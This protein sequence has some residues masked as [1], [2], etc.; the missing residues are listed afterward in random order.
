MNFTIEDL[1]NQ[2]TDVQ[3]RQVNKRITEI[4]EKRKEQKL[5][6]LPSLNNE[7]IHF[8]ESGQ[9]IKAMATY[10]QRTQVGL[11]NSKWKV[12]DYLR[13]RV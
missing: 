10:A 11:I 3:L 9:K 8:A 4:L 13:N 2:L 12:E 1:L 7:E 5:E 6:S